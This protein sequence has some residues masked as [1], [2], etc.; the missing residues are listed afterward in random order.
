MSSPAQKFIL[1][2]RKLELDDDGIYRI[3]VGW[4][5]SLEM[6]VGRDRLQMGVRYD[7]CWNPSA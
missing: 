2:N 5:N 4:Y 1:R 6:K 7:G 3:P